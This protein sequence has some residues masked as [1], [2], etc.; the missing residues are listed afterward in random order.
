VVPQVQAEQVALQEP[1]AQVAA[2]VHQA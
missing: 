2:Q 1:V